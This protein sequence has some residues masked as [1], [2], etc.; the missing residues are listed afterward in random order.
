M[1][2]RFKELDK[3]YF[4]ICKKTGIIRAIRIYFFNRL[5]LKTIC[6]LLNHF[7]ESFER[8]GYIEVKRNK[9]IVDGKPILIDLCIKKTLN[10]DQE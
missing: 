2:Y 6:F 3:T 5:I 8:I 4:T 10:K 1:K 7:N 9:I